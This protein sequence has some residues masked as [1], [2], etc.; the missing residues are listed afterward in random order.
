MNASYFRLG[1]ESDILPFSLA[2]HIL[3]ADKEVAAQIP[4]FTQFCVMK[5]D[6]LYTNTHTHICN[7][8][9]QG[10]SRNLDIPH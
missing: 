5:G 9:G 8:V 1:I 3:F 6:C 7:S 10:K 2:Q 4:D